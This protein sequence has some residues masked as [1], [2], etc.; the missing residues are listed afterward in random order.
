MPKLFKAYH[1]DDY[2]YSG[3]TMENFD[4]KLAL[5]C[6]SCDPLAVLGEE[7]RKELS[8]IL[9]HLAREYSLDSLNEKTKTSIC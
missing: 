7:R 5:L 8:M 4:R 6:D 3:Q 9:A 2:L 1:V